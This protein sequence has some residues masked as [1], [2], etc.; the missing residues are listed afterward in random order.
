M[1]EV[2]CLVDAQGY[3]LIFEKSE[4]RWCLLL[5]MGLSFSAA[6]AVWWAVK[7]CMSHVAVIVINVE[8]FRAQVA[9]R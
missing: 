9:S 7:Q 1:N 4:G 2:M 3:V 5:G 6:A 8:F